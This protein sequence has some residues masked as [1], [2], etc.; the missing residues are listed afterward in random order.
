[1]LGKRTLQAAVTGTPYAAAVGDA[2]AK[3]E[4]LQRERA[5]RVSLPD[6]F[7]SS[8]DQPRVDEPLRARLLEAA[9]AR[10]VIAFEYYTVERDAVSD[11]VV[12]PFFLYLH[13]R[14]LQ[15]IAYC[16]TRAALLSFHVSCVRAL[17]VLEERFDPEARAF[18]LEEF[19]ATTFDGQR[20]LPVL[21]VRL[22]IREPSARW[23]RAH[24]Y[25]QAQEIEDVA[26][27]VEIRFRAGAPQAIAARVL[28]LGPDCEV[29]AP[30]ELRRLVAEQARAIWRLYEDD[31]NPGP[32]LSGGSGSV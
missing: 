19:L 5:R 6:V 28:S 2:L 32:D 31:P 30:P 26:G 8:F 10:R 17:R 29:L 7:Q 16:R 12:E 1:M 21:D 4:A 24:F 20:G 13:P 14:G 18:D 15:L 27:G 23:A 11:R 9:L 25:H 22:R 3:V